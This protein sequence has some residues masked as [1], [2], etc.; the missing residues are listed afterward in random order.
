MER[1]RRLE[2]AE[3]LLREIEDPPDGFDARVRDFLA[4]AAKEGKP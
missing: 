3:E 1:L 2:R 4:D